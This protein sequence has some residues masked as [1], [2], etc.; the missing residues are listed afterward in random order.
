MDCGVRSMVYEC[1]GCRQQQP[2]NRQEGTI[3]YR[4]M[5]YCLLFNSR[6]LMFKPEKEHFCYLGSLFML[7]FYVNSRTLMQPIAQSLHR[8]VN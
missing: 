7:S 3:F 8:P 6:L 1:K 2:K 5:E 4:F